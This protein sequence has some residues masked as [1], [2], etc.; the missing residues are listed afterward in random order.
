M[1][2]PKFK[3]GDVVRYSD[4][5]GIGIVN[6]KVWDSGMLDL[7]AWGSEDAILR[8]DAGAW[9]EGCGCLND[10]WPHEDPDRIL[11][12]YMAAKLCGDVREI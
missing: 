10:Y 1:A 12:L 8:G 7:Q 6:D 11:A 3:P 2:R 9:I 4:G 5:H